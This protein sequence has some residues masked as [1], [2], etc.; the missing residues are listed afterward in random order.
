MELYPLKFEQKLLEKVWG[1]RR[2]AEIGRVLPE[3]INVRIGESWELVD[4]DAVSSVV[5]NGPLQG[6][7]LKQIISKFGAK[8][9]GNLEMGEDGRFPLLV[10]YLD[11]ATNL[12]VQVHP[13]KAYA[14]A[15]PDVK[16]KSEAWYVIEADKDSVIYRGLKAGISSDIFKSH[17]GGNSDKLVDDLLTLPARA[18]DFYFLP[19]GTCHAL[20]AGVMVLEIQTPSD[21]TF[22]LYDWGRT[23]R[24]LHI[25]QALACMD[26]GPPDVRRNEKRSHIG[27]VFTT[28]SKIC[29]CE[30]FL[31]EKVRMIEGFGQEIPYDRPAVWVVLEGAGVISN[32]PALVDVPF[33]QWDVILI[34]AGMDEARVDLLADTVWLDIQFPRLLDGQPLLA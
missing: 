10:K 30:H 24:E 14:E 3:D 8:L 6:Q 28:V 17:V 21:T 12:S 15:H 23:E 25:E 19:S 34:P 4:M 33:G 7:T 11:A 29:S 31:I 5:A 1:G 20:G 18:G 22:R 9:T 13:D 16:L 27:G 26:Y 32:T 2:L